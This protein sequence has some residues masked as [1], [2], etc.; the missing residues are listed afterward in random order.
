MYTITKGDKG[1]WFS[2]KNGEERERRTRR[3]S[4]A[5]MIGGEEE[6]GGEGPWQRDCSGV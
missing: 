2:A 5:E 1:Q 4:T 3:M 6:R